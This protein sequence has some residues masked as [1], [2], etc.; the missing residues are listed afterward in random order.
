ME[1]FTATVCIGGYYGVMK[2]RYFVVALVVIVVVIA[3][4]I[5]L[6]SANIDSFRPRIQAEMQEKLNRPVTLGH[7]GLRVIPLSIRVDGFSIGDDPSFHSAQP[8]ATASKVYVSAGLFSLITGNPKV[9]DIVL[10]QPQIDLIRNAQGK[11]NFSSLGGASTSS[12]GNSNFRLDKLQIDDGKVALTDALNHEPRN[13]YDHIDLTVTDFAEN[14]KFGVDLAVHLPGAG[15]QLAEFKG[16]VGP[17]NQN[18]KTAIPPVSGRVSVQQVSLA[19]V[20]RFAAGTLPPQT[21]SVIS[22][23][24]KINTSGSDLSANGDLKFEN[25]V[26]RGAKIDYPIEAK[27]D[28]AA[29]QALNNIS[30]K[31][32]A[33]TLGSTK[34]DVAG[35][36]D[37][38]VKPAQ[39][40]MQ[41]KTQ[42][43]SL[44]EMA[45][46][47]G[48]MGIAFS[49]Q[50]KI[51]GRLSVNLTAKGPVTAPQLNGNIT[52]KNV[53][54]SGGEIKEPVS[55]PEI[56][57]AMTPQ[58][59]VS[60][61]FE[62]KS[63]ST[64]LNVAFTLTNYTTKDP[65]ADVTLRSNGAQIAELLN[66][67]KAYGVATAQGMS[68]TGTLTVDVHMHGDIAQPGSLIYAGSASINNAIISTPEL[69]KPVSV[70]SAN[71]QFSQNSVALTNLA[72]G[73]GSTNLTGTLS[74][75]DFAAPVL[76]FALSADK[77]DTDELQSLVANTP[78]K[79]SSTQTSSN[80]PSA[81]Q[82]A[83]G[84]GT[85]A[86]NTIK[87]Q[88][89]VLTAVSTKVAL[90]RGLITLSPLSA[91]AFNGKINGT[92]TADVRQKI[93]QCSI[94]AKLS[95]MDANALLSAVS[96]VKNELFGSLNATTNLKFALVSSNE[97]PKTLNGTVD[98][99]VANGELKNV[100]ILSEVAK[101]SK[102][103]NASTAPSSSGSSTALKQFSGTLNI[104]SGVATTNNL[105]AVTDSGSLAANG[106]L[107]LVNEGIDMHMAATL[108][109][110]LTLP[111]LVTG[112]TSHMMF[113]PDM[114]GLAKMKLGN[115]GGALN[116]LLGTQTP[117]GKQQPQSN[118]LNSI[119]NSLTKKKQ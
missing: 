6:I 17:L 47:A 70:R 53:S 59:I 71:A 95:G 107:N 113:A 33:L 49:P 108:G 115:V 112:T 94:N 55:T 80:Q 62:A 11:W 109:K 5:G 66:I 76:Q 89:I 88:E 68:G 35:S 14:K 16:D 8:F 105:K 39:V 110:G 41:V 19:A 50:Y 61:N 104:A 46:L 97:L 90:N 52:A 2:I 72:A 32:G 3:I 42:D 102:F 60:N 83:T 119:L 51:E 101:V 114:Q 23:E 84:G 22:G 10:D 96:P 48:A 24:T 100:N 111:V 81:L 18:A 29:D 12:G 1:K 86:V 99:A 25:T 30:V 9:E 74:A 65:V 118:P 67:A 26:V 13:V 34:F 27:Y 36:F 7:L 54:A 73:V 43:T 20:N 40:N 15:K 69:T 37:N 63:G 106:S 4:G 82:S 44:T 45:K 77:I 116:G 92:L 57:L 117:A 56:D 85:L 87:A 21:D 98:F 91:N 78:A 79:S 93:S 103:L 31:S 75:K 58:S 38:A 28:V 64:A